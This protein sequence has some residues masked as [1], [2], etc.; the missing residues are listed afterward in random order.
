MPDEPTTVFATGVYRD[1]VREH[2][3]EWLFAEKLC[4]YD[5]LISNSLVLPF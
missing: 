1:L 5:G 2:E 4:I 3:G